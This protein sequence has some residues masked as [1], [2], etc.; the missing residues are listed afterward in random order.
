MKVYFF[1]RPTDQNCLGRKDAKKM[2]LPQI[3]GIFRNFNLVIHHTSD[4]TLKHRLT[5]KAHQFFLYGRILYNLVKIWVQIF[6]YLSKAIIS[7]PIQSWCISYL[8]VRARAL[9]L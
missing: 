6:N 2:L 7:I 9:L 5:R 3:K 8:G 1:A 4:Q